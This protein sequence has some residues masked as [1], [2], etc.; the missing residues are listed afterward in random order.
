MTIDTKKILN[1]NIVN[2]IKQ[3]IK[4]IIPHDQAEFISQ[5]LFV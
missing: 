2:Q 3:N 4:R 5:Q 1:K